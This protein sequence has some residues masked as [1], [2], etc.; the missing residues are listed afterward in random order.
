MEA[1]QAEEQA[2][3]LLGRQSD[4]EDDGESQAHVEME[5]VRDLNRR[6]SI[7]DLQSIALCC[8]ALDILQTQIDNTKDVQG[9][10]DFVQ[11][12]NVIR[13]KVVGDAPSLLRLFLERI[14]Y[15]PTKETKSKIKALPKPDTESLYE[16][17]PDLD[18]LLTLANMMTSMSDSD[19][20]TFK[21]YHT[22]RNTEYGLD[23]ITYRCKLLELMLDNNTC[24]ELGNFTKSFDDCYLS[25]PKE[26]VRYLKRH[27]QPVPIQ[28]SLCKSLLL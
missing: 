16:K 6:L 14:R 28:W 19:F 3:P 12:Y 22:P 21:N 8:R 24:L 1:E 18:M 9:R 5:L 26:L 27:R 25:Y 2:E 20:D 10:A 17:Y 7:K 23:A 4:S 15:K 11:L 13:E